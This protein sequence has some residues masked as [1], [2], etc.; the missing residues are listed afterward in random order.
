M[1]SRGGVLEE[2][3]P[4]SR[5]AASEGIVLLVNDDEL[6]PLGKHSV[7]SLF[8]RCQIDSYRSGTGSGGAVHV[9]Y[10]INALDGMRANEDITLNEDLVSTYETWLAENPFDDGGGGWAAEPWSQKEMP[11]E[12]HTVK[13]AAENSDL[14]MIFIGRTAGESKDHDDAP[15]SYRLAKSEEEMIEKVTRHFGKVVLIFNTTAI[16]DMSWI[17]KIEYKESIKAV[18]CWWAGG[19]ESGH[20]LADILSGRVCPSGRMTDTVA[21]H[22][23]DYPTT[24]NFGHQDANLYEEDIYLGYRYFET[25]HRDAV[26]FPFGS[27]LSYTKFVYERTRLSEVREKDDTNL[28]FELTIR[29]I[30]DRYAG[31]EIVQIYCESP[32]GKLGKPSRVLVGFA[33]TQCLRPGESQDIKISIPLS[34]LSSYDDSSASGYKSCYVLE[35]G[36]YVFYVGGNIRDVVRVSEEVFLDKLK[37]VERH[38]ECLAPIHSFMR[39]KPQP[40]VGNNKFLIVEEKVPVRSVDLQERISVSLPETIPQTEDRGIK[41]MD[42]VKGSSSL[43]DFI[44][45]IPADDLATLLLGEGMCSP[46]VTPGTAAAFG[47]TTPGLF[48]FGIPTAC[49]A[50]G[51]SGIRM[52]TGQLATQV[53]IGTMLACT[54]NVEL[55]QRLFELVGKELINNEIDTLLGPGINIHR[56][57][58]N[59]RNFEY[60]SEDPLLTG[61]IASAQTRGLRKGGVVGTIKHF[62]AN[63]QE[64]SRHD[65]DSVVSERALRE[66]HL[67]P[68]EIAVKRGGASSIMTSYNPINGHWAASNYD[69]NTSILRGEWGY[70]GLVMT[71]WW[72]ETNHNSSGGEKSKKQADFMVRAQNDLYMVVGNDEAN[73]DSRKELILEAIVDGRLSL[74]ELQRSAMNVCRFLMNSPSMRRPLLKYQ[75]IKEFFPE[76]GDFDETLP[77]D[78]VVVFEAGSDVSRILQVS[79]GGIHKVIARVRSHHDRLAQ[80]ACSIYFGDCFA[81]SMSVNGTNGEVRELELEEVKLNAGV[82]TIGLDFV[83]PGMEIESLTFQRII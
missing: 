35:E 59:G 39:I 21:Y 78:G 19:M 42:V 51:P 81:M 1:A 75:T 77:E 76:K 24:K 29:N 20:A 5:Q 60:F 80:S 63:D 48:H 67:K 61:E 27:G 43:K 72:A 3:A 55:N 52:D 74:G 31:K 36:S 58:L 30:G 64:A 6:L 82:Y 15:G 7:V 14:A 12:C 62:A 8:G 28:L 68:F 10:A 49:A 56:H 44:A 32:Q 57:P 41:L 18:L 2:I 45:Q 4:V 69:L 47:G 34:S 83:K 37:V 66:I 17:E 53:P 65:V 73:A 71:D 33:K 25:F 11:L 79:E 70:S 9:P 13:K 26:Q 22:L 23:D 50:D 54:W 40:S 16:M 38:Q 46:K